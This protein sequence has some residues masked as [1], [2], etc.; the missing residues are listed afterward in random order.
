MYKKIICLTSVVLMLAMVSPTLA[1][2]FHFTN[3][4]EGGGGDGLWGTDTNW[5]DTD[6]GGTWGPYGLGNYY[7]PG[8]AGGN[9]WAVIGDAAYEPGQT[10]TV[11]YNSPN[12]WGLTIRDGGVVVVAGGDIDSRAGSYIGEVAGRTG[13]L[14]VE[15]GG[16]CNLANNGYGDREVFIGDAGTGTVNVWGDFTSGRSFRLGE[17]K[18]GV[19]TLNVHDGAVVRNLTNNRELRVGNYGKG[20]IN[21]DGGY[22]RVTGLLKITD[23]DE[24]GGVRVWTDECE[25]HVEMSGGLIEAPY[26]YFDINTESKAQGSPIIRGTIHQT[27]GEFLFDGDD[28]DLVL[29]R[30]NEAINDGWWTTDP[31]LV[32]KVSQDEDGTHVNVALVVNV[33]ILPDDDPNLLSQNADTKSRLPI[34][35]RS[36]EEYDINQIDVNSISIAGLVFPVKEPKATGDTL[37]IHVS[38]RELILALGLD[39]MEPGTVVPITIDGAMMGGS[40]LIVGT[41]EVVLQARED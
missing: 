2:T 15:A 25:G 24:V 3:N 4:M 18:T 7:V 5:F 19:G 21:I 22:I 32:L 11:D 20:T 39:M 41:D 13:V 36:S 9:H 14:T 23:T 35:I 17:E 10:A 30:V 31:D 12:L 8:S 27:G 28:Q 29:A 16:D 1:A 38:K 40:P 33:D 6:P 26:V 34:A 37:M